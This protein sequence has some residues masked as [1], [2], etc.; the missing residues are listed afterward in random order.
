MTR[1]AATVSRQLSFIRTRDI[2]TSRFYASDLFVEA[3]LLAATDVQGSDNFGRRERQFSHRFNAKNQIGAS[4]G[5]S[6]AVASRLVGIARRRAR[7]AASIRVRT[8]SL[9]PGRAA[10]T[11]I[12]HIA[13]MLSRDAAK[14]DRESDPKPLAGFGLPAGR[15]K[16]RASRC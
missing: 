15:T 3:S 7:I 9:K 11:P 13:S 16:M 2:S 4:C 5:I 14:K 12:A 6:V 10:V 8:T 1:V